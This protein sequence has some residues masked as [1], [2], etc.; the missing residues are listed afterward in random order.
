MTKAVPVQL[1]EPAMNLIEKFAV[2]AVLGVAFIPQD[3]QHMTFLEF[4]Q[5]D[6][7]TPAQRDCL[8]IFVENVGNIIELKDDVI[9]AQADDIAEIK[10]AVEALDFVVKPCDGKIHVT[11]LYQ[12]K[13]LL[14][15]VRS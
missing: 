3:K 14:N 1:P 8:K 12:Y 9:K 11:Q 4:I 15:R 10:K 5:Q 13:E 6:H 2:C 7:V